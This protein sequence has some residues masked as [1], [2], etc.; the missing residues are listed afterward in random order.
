MIAE[1]A[2]RSPGRTRAWDCG[3]GNGQAAYLVAEHFDEVVATDPSR[4][5]LE[6]ARPH[7]RVRYQVAT[8]D[9]TGLETAS[10]DLVTAAQALH[11]LDLDRFYA[12][13]E[14]VLVPNGLLAVWCYA[15]ARIRPAIDEVVDWFHDTRMAPFWPVERR[16]VLT[17]YRELPFPFAEISVGP[18]TM[19]LDYSRSRFLEYVATWSA[20][21][22]ARDAEA[23]DPMADL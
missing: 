14:R 1:F 7:P 3:T 15:R 21:K 9:A 18:W 23:M 11:W 16:H 17:G 19:S 13:V 22:A 10:V 5:Q 12:E 2:A 8:E 4:R 20:V 6:H